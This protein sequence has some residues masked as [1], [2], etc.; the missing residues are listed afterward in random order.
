MF[1]MSLLRT[2]LVKLKL[3]IFLMSRQELGVLVEGCVP[4]HIL[5]YNQLV[6]N[7]IGLCL[8]IK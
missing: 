2:W 4:A 7:E 8:L 5:F 6:P 1:G 3:E